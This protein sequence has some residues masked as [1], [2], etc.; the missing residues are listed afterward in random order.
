MKR[1]SI[2]LITRDGSVRPQESRR[3]F[4]AARDVRAL[5]DCRDQPRQV[6]GRVLEVAVHR[7]E[8]LAARANEPGVHRGVL[9]EVPLQADDADTVVGGV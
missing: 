9:A 4:R 1:R 6:L 3:A 5:L 2:P 7:H 8:D